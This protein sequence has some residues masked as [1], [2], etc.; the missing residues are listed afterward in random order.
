MENTR[1]YVLYEIEK[2]NEYISSLQ[3]F[4]PEVKKLVKTEG[5][6][7][8]EE[9][10]DFSKYKNVQSLDDLSDALK[11]NEYLVVELNEETKEKVNPDNILTY[12]VPARKNERNESKR[13]IGDKLYFV[14]YKEF[15]PKGLGKEQ[16]SVPSIVKMNPDETC[17]IEGFIFSGDS[18]TELESRLQDLYGGYS[19]VYYLV[20]DVTVLDKYTDTYY[21]AT[22]TNEDSWEF[23]KI[24]NK[25]TDGMKK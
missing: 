21:E 13:K 18:I 10:Y 25:K 6:C 7:Y 8:I 15:S 22:K 17:S 5:G 9:F 19:G 20:N 16:D 23:I 2:T 3:K 12:V 1:Y 24:T 14:K 11:D 4:S